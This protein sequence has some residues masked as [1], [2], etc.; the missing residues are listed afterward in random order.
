MAKSRTKAGGPTRG[1]RRP[2]RMGMN[3][4]KFYAEKKKKRG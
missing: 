3:S 1:R 2:K 4:G